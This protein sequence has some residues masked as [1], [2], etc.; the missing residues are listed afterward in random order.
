LS[1]KPQK[2]LTFEEYLFKQVFIIYLDKI[3][4]IIGPDTLNMDTF[5]GTTTKGTPVENS[6]VATKAYIKAFDAVCNGINRLKQFCD[7][8]EIVLN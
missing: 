4:F 8:L 3:V 2:F 6:E 7:K 5:D 1:S